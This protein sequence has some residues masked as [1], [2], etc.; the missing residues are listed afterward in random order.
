MPRKHASAPRPRNALGDFGANGVE[1]QVRHRRQQSRLL[2]A[3]VREGFVA[4]SSAA[5]AAMG[6]KADA[7]VKMKVAASELRAPDNDGSVRP[8]G[9]GLVCA[10]IPHSAFSLLGVAL[11]MTNKM[12]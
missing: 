6:G 11:E 4:T 12:R 8:A 1:M 9:K 10:R 5:C 3:P 2:K 7:A